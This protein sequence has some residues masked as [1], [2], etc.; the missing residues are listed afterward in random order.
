MTHKMLLLS[1]SRPSAALVYNREY[2][3]HQTILSATNGQKAL[4][5][6]LA[7]PT[8]PPLLR[9]L[10]SAQITVPAGWRLEGEQE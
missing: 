1:A 4:W 5:V 8:K 6:D 7:G 3:C 2:V 10:T 9:V